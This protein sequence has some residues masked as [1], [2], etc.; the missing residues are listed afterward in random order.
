M[1]Q[2]KVYGQLDECVDE[3]CYLGSIITNTGSCDK[4]VKTRISKANSAFK[5][6]D[7]IWRQKC[8]GLPMKIRLYKSLV[9]AILLYCAETWPVTEANRKR[10]EGLHHNYLRRI[11]NIIME[12][13]SKG[14]VCQ[15]KDR[16]V[17]A[18]MY[19]PKRRL[20]WFGHVQRVEN[21]SRAR[22]ALHWIPTEKRKR[23][24]PRITWRD[25]V[26][27]DISQMNATW[28]GICQTA[29]YRQEWRVWTTQCA[30]H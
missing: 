7:D 29:M 13:Q 19:I 28:D 18:R 17:I 22:Q 14:Q 24:R 3:F 11:L 6:L 23:G 12:R 20:R 27:K 10:L 5:R 4:E 8:L 15:E 2:L 16:S 9:L 25:T 30:S 26:M 1:W 21:V